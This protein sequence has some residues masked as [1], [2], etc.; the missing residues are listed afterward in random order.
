MDMFMDKLA[1]KLNAQEIIR[2]NTAAD[3]EEL[4]RL[5]NQVAEYNECL[6]RLQKLIEE[7]ASSLQSAQAGSADINRLVEESI[8]KIQ[9]IQQDKAGLESIG[10]T[11]EELKRSFLKVD[12]NCGELVRGFEN[13]EKG[14]EEQLGAAAVAADESVHKEC[15]KVYRNVQA[16]VVEESD[17]QL[18]AAEGIAETVKA[19]ESKSNAILGISVAAL[20]FSLAGVVLQIMNMLNLISF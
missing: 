9:A 13:L 16:V 4:N 3:T 14:V 20:V 12:E 7:G 1:Q 15:V 17:K 2:A 19:S 6:A 11:L 10:R 18:K 8:G 5:K